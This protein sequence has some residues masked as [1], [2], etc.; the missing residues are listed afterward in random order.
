MSSLATV[1][2]RTMAVWVNNPGPDVDFTSI[3]VHPG[4]FTS[5]V[6]HPGGTRPVLRDHPPP[7]NDAGRE[8][9]IAWWTRGICFANCQRSGTHAPFASGAERSRL[10]TF[11]REHLAAP[12]AA[13][14]SRA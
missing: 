14:A 9:C 5:I 3:V 1:D 11:Y 4:G 10:L 2:A 7:Q 12:A 6:V 8:F 13:G